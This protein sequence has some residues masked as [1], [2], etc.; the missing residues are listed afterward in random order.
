MILVRNME[1]VLQKRK[2]VKARVDLKGQKVGKKKMEQYFSV[3]F[4]LSMPGLQLKN[5]TTDS[6]LI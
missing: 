6:N 2:Q 5:V 4:E 1:L 3:G